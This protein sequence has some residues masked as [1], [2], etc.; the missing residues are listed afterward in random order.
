MSVS[1]AQESAEALVAESP[2]LVAALANLDQDRARADPSQSTMS[3]DWD[4]ASC[5]SG[6][7]ADFFP[8]G[9]ANR[10]DE[11]DV[12]RRICRRCPIRKDCLAWSLAY[13]PEG[14][15]GGLTAPERWGLGA[16]RPTVRWVLKPVPTTTS[17]RSAAKAI[18]TGIPAPD[19]AAAI[20]AAL[21]AEPHPV[22]AQRMTTNR[23]AA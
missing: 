19:V 14:V 17:T 13:E 11:V 9:G 4:A 10:P 23:V 1:N 8:A 18:K 3:V 5:A 15:W 16:P 7:R 20:D 21:S 12:L 22:A 6:G 2:A